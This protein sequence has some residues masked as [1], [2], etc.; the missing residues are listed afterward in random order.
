MLIKLNTNANFFRIS[1]EILQNQIEFLRVAK[2][3]E[4]SIYC[5]FLNA[6]E[7]DIV[8]VIIFSFFCSSRIRYLRVFEN[9]VFCQ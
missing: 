4:L 7:I 8:V 5:I 3:V 6:F 2:R 9:R 1:N